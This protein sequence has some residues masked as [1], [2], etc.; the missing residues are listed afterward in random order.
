M[1]IS[2]YSPPHHFRGK[3]EGG[4][5]GMRRDAGNQ[6]GER[7]RNKK[8]CWEP[9]RFPASQGRRQGNMETGSWRG[10]ISQG[11]R[12]GLGTCAKMAKLWGVWVVSVVRDSGSC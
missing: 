7:Q 10:G 3:E 2:R 12:D 4:D 6:R 9:E 5:R 8:G 11:M 1:Q